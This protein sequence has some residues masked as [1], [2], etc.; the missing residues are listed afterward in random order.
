[1]AD[2]VCPET[3]APMHR[4]TRPMTLT[5]KD[6]SIT[7][8]MPGWYRA[9]SRESRHAGEHMKASDRILNLLKAR[10]ERA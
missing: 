9:E 7:F 4:G 3:G 2:P 1:M 6:Q 5:C 10:S 8:D